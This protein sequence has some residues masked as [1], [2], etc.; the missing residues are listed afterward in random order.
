MTHQLT[1]DSDIE[2]LI[3]QCQPVIEAFQ[4]QLGERLVALVLF[5]SRARGDHHSDSDWDL[6]L[7]AKALPVKAFERH[8]YLKRMLPDLWRGQV[9]ILAKTPIELESCLSSLFLDISLDGVILA[10]TN[11]YMTKRLADLRQMIQ[12]KGLRRDRRDQDFVWH[13]HQQPDLNWELT[14]DTLS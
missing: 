2:S 11:G 6:L 13:W 5:G 14:W 1:E 9:S 10:D 12:S 4:Q 7:V 3:Q 8:L